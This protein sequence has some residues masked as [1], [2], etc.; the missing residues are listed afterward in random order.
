MLNTAE[1]LQHSDVTKC[2]LPYTTSLGEVITVN[3][4]KFIVIQS[5]SNSSRNGVKDYLLT[6]F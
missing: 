4:T 1:L 3:K 2:K 5:I 6:P